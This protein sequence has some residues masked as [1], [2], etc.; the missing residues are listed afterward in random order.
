MRSGVRSPSAP[1]I[2]TAVFRLPFKPILR[3]CDY[4][5]TQA[6]GLIAH[7]LK[8]ASKNF[9]DR[10]STTSLDWSRLERFEPEGQRHFMNELTDAIDSM[11]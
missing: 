4:S 1:P 11:Q 10:D 3:L 8:N 7:S 2:N 5:V 9:I 6:S